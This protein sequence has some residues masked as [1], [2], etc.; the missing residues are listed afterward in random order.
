MI[1][2]IGVHQFDDLTDA[3]ERDEF[4]LL[5]EDTSLAYGAKILYSYKFSGTFDSGWFFSS[6]LGYG[7]SD[8]KSD[9]IVDLGFSYHF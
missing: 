9:V 7:K 1:G 5:G 2:A 8:V 4:L 6:G 3:E